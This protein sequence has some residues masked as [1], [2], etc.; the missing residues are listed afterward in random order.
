MQNT[1]LEEDDYVATDEKCRDLLNCG[2]GNVWKETETE[3]SAMDIHP[4]NIASV[5]QS[6]VS[7]SSVM[8][9]FKIRRELCERVLPAER[10]TAGKPVIP[11]K[12]N[13]LYAKVKFT[14]NNGALEAPTVVSRGVRADKSSLILGA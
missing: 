6:T 2:C 10:L 1:A 5:S 13:G 4:G 14:I 3:Q 8:T 12:V 11:R 7:V 9:S